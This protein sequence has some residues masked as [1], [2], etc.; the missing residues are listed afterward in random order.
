MDLFQVLENIIR[1]QVPDCPD[2]ASAL[3]NMG[4]PSVSIAVMDGH[5][6]IS[7]CI[8]TSRDDAETVFQA[9]SISKP[10]AGYA[11]MQLVQQ[12]LL[13]LDEP[14][15]TYLTKDWIDILKTPQSELRP[16]F[17]RAA[18]YERGTKRVN[19]VAYL[20]GWPG[21]PYT[22]G[23][24]KFHSSVVPYF[25]KSVTVPE[26]CKKRAGT[27][28]ST[29]GRSELRIE[30]IEG[31]LCCQYGDLKTLRLVPAAMPSQGT[32]NSVNLII[33]GFQIMVRLREVPVDTKETERTVELLAANKTTVEDNSLFPPSNYF[34]C[35]SQPQKK[36]I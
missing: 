31:V 32:D 16:A 22:P 13:K 30:E 4:S 26:K 36:A 14:I 29:I 18:I 23:L 6:I 25:D 12:G 20:K 35:H 27:W 7:K 28:E 15:T 2:T 33:E 19:A 10:V 17:F 8:S 5:E 24:S 21:T 11:V 3:A 34:A 1:S 9:Y